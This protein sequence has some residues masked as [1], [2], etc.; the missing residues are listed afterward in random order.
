M[1]KM[2]D[3]LTRIIDHQKYQSIMNVNDNTAPEIS[4]NILLNTIKTKN[5]KA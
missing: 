5:G 2:F 4:K 1:R 3:C